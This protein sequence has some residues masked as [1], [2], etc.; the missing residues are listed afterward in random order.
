MKNKALFTR[1]HCL[2]P[3]T[4]AAPLTLQVLFEK[5]EVPP[6]MVARLARPPFMCTTIS[7]FSTLFEKKEDIEA[8]LWPHLNAAD[9]D[10]N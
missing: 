10:R 9:A 8:K 5:Q 2:I 1:S 4:M 6:A 7:N 3:A